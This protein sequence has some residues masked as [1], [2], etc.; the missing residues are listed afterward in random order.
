M[1]D[2]TRPCG[3][4]GYDLQGLTANLCPECGKQI[5]DAGARETAASLVE[6]VRNGRMTVAELRELWPQY[7]ADT[8]VIRA[9]AEL[10]Q[11]LAE[12]RD[13][14]L[15]D[16]LSRVE[17]VR[18]FLDRWVVF[19]RAECELRPASVRTQAGPPGPF[20]RPWATPAVVTAIALGVV[21]WVLATIAGPL[22]IAIVAGGLVFLAL[23]SLSLVRQL[24]WTVRHVRYSE[25]TRDAEAVH[26]FRSRAELEAARDALAEKSR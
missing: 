17:R 8:T 5:I 23:T 19:L 7:T 14:R 1:I 15:T 13:L 9:G 26:P 11:G 2:M 16:D 10:W 20:L 12:M 25:L 22:W 18:S 4:C 21:C 3:S 24:R 6:E